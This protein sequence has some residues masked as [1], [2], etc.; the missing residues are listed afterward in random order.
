MLRR[1][2][3][4]KRTEATNKEIGKGLRKAWDEGRFVRPLTPSYRR[5]MSV[6]AKLRVGPKNSFYG[7]H[8]T[9]KTIAINRAAHIGKTPWNKG[10]RLK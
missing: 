9:A 6:K 5:K 4:M 8:H 7:K 3:K 2:I 1:I 10:K